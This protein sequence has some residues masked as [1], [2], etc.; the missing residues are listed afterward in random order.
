MTSNVG[1]VARAEALDRVLHMF[2]GLATEDMPETASLLAMAE[3][4]LDGSG[5]MARG[6]ERLKHELYQRPVSYEEPMRS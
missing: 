3:W 2:R 5:D 6:L 4:I 1:Q